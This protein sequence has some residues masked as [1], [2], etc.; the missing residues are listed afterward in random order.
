MRQDGDCK[1]WALSLSPTQVVSI[2]H[3]L[4]SLVTGGAE[5][6]L[7]DF[8]EENSGH[9][10][11]PMLSHGPF[12]CCVS[13]HC[14]ESQ[15]WV[16]LEGREGARERESW[17][18]HHPHFFLTFLITRKTNSG[19]LTNPCPGVKHSHVKTQ[20]SQQYFR[21]GLAMLSIWHMREG[22]LLK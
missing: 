12:L 3:A 16:Q 14:N 7:C 15:L 21:V 13:F 5:R 2:L 9:C 6:V 4:S 17:Y 19:A 11:L 22:G 1:N 20:S 18:P 8:Q 10:Y